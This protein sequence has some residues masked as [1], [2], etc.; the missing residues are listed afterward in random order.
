MNFVS[1]EFL[2]FFP[3]VL[4]LY[5]WL[6]FRYRW[7]FLL[8][9]SY[10]FYLYWAPWTLVLLFG[11]TLISFIAA[12]AVDGA[13]SKAQGKFWLVLALVVCLGCLIVFKYLGFLMDNVTALLQLFGAPKQDII[14]NIFLPVGISFY[15]F[16]A[17]SY[18]IDV[19]RKEIHSETHFGYFALFIAYFPQVVAGPIERPTNLLPQLRT[20][21][22]LKATDLLEGLR[23]ALR[24]FFKKVVIADYLAVFVNA[25]YGA[26]EQAKGPAIVIATILF[27]FQIYCDFSGYSDIAVGVA[28]MMGIRLMTNFDN[29]YSAISIQEFWRK[30]HISLTSWF[31]DYIY[32][33]LGGSHKGMIRRCVNVMIVFLISGVW[34]GASWTFI[35]WGGIHG[36]Y[37]VIGILW[38]KFRGERFQKKPAG[39]GRYGRVCFT[40]SLVCFAWLFFRAGS[41][42]EANLLL[43][44]L[45]TGWSAQGVISTLQLLQLNGLDVTRIILMLACLPVLEKLPEWLEPE[46][47]SAYALGSGVQKALVVFQMITLIGLAWLAL[48]SIHGSSSFIYFQF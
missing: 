14:L 27:A 18:V 32:K 6:P 43:K 20:L 42:T 3:L 41:L 40:F 4:I 23:L 24:G 36:V 15:T 5:W 48:L 39:I 1:L 44:H 2:L 25:V 19:Y 12:R 47:D 21:Q 31:S 11:T 46:T 9:A 34:H 26:P 10:L 22:T 35:I 16:Q 13:Q 38:R 45:V 30:W 7:A 17:L 37:S 33:P 8:A 28:R 29:P